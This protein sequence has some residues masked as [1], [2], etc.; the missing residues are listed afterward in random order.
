MTPTLDEQGK[1]A[2]RKA[3]R[4]GVP[5]SWWTCGKGTSTGGRSLGSDAF[6]SQ[7]NNQRLRSVSEVNSVY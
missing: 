4:T 5:P 7:H 3:R 6:T 1:G 2:V